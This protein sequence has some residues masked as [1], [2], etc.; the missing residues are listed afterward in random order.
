MTLLFRRFH[1]SP[2]FRLDVGDG[3]LWKDGCEILLGRKPFAI[4]VH[5]ATHQNRLVTQDELLETVLGKQAASESLVRT[6]VHRLRVVLG[7]G[8][9]QTVAGRG[10]RFL[11]AVD[12]VDELRSV[13]DVDVPK[14][15][16]TS[17]STIGRAQELAC[18][19]THFR[20]ARER[21]RQLLFIDGDQGLGKT[22]LV[23]AFIEQTARGTRLVSARG[24][25]SQPFG[26][27]EPYVALFDAL[28]DLCRGAHR[29]RVV[30]VLARYAP[31]WL[32]QM[33]GI[34][35]DAEEE[36]LR[37]RVRD[38]VEPRMLRELAEALD[39]IAAQTPL[40]I[41]LEDLQWADAATLNVIAALARSRT[42]SR[43]LLIAT[44]RG[45]E[46]APRR[47]LAQVIG[48]ATIEGRADLISL[49]S[50]TE[51]E[52]SDYLAV[53]FGRHAFPSGLAAA[54]GQLAAGNP[55]FTEILVDE[56]ESSRLLSPKDGIWTLSARS[57]QS[58]RGSRTAFV[59]RWTSRWSGTREPAERAA[60]LVKERP[61]GFW[62]P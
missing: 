4:L 22:T 60:A 35:T 7:D 57:R 45:S 59:R 38:S 43:M 19:E 44:F 25:C 5:L 10:Y 40:V 3:K 14:L 55:L 15:A 2:A 8:V 32:L 31:T 48:D 52:V 58:P 34:A 12:N 46:L 56:L 53:R 61:A 30:E 13:S 29:K 17:R 11:P 39:A 62:P 42:P 23:D 51:V 37:L 33:P 49:G 9:I 36:R 28:A 1:S 21:Q 16:K 27:R 20:R 47:H 18:L 41:V 50:W 6:H 24:A 54:I 26:R